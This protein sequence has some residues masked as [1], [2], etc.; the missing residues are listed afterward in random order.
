ML[1]CRG[2][3]I[4][5]LRAVGEVPADTEKHMETNNRARSAHPAHTESEPHTHTHKLGLIST[6]EEGDEGVPSVF[7][8]SSE[9]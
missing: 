6:D 5:P 3:A 2:T 9:V 1:G 7:F 8:T 4:N